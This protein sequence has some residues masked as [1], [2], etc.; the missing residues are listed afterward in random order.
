MTRQRYSQEFLRRLRNEIPTDLV[1]QRLAW[2]SRQREGRFV[3]L[4]PE[5]HETESGI[6]R[7]TNLAHCFHCHANF[8]PIDFTMTIMKCDFADAVEFLKP[9]LPK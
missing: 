6:H 2:P 9:L 3:F 7:A 4:C 8:N 5:C 1:I